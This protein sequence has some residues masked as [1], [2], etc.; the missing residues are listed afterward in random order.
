MKCI[1]YSVTLFS[2]F[3][4]TACHKSRE[5]AP[6]GL[7]LNSYD[8]CVYGG[9]SAGVIAA[10]TA[11]KA[12]KNVL[13]IEPGT[14]LGGLTSGG[15]C[16][17]DVGN[18]T[19]ITGLAKDFYKR[20]GAL[21]GVAVR[22]AFEPKTALS[23]FNQMVNEA[24]ITVMYKTQLN[25]VKKEGTTI[26]ELDVQ[27][28]GSPAITAIVAKEFIDC[29]YEGDLMA[30][31]KVSYTIGRES[32]TAYQETLNGVHLS[33]A[34]QFPNGIDP[35]KIP[36]DPA[37][38]LLWGI[39]SEPLAAEGT[40]DHKIQAYNYRVCLT[41]NTVNLQPITRPAGYDSTQYELLLRYIRKINATDIKTILT[42]NP[43]PNK[44]ADINNQ[45]PFSTDMI[46]E[47]YT[48]PDGDRATRTAIAQ[49]CARYTK[50][51]LYFIGHDPRMPLSIRNQM[52]QW[53]YPLD[54]F[55]ENEHFTSQL[56]IRESRRMLGEYITTQANCEHTSVV[57]D[58]V[59]DA[60]Y[61]MDS[62]NCQRIVVNG[63]VKNEGNV[64]K[65]VRGPYSVSYRSIT[66]KRT[67]CTNL[68]VPVCLSA[69]HIAYGSIRMEPV[70]MMLG[71][72]AA[73]AASLAIDAKTSVQAIDTRVLQEQ[74]KKLNN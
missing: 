22:W 16:W 56:Y 10:Y 70:F 6:A 71:Q 14:R 61:M 46:G 73:Q 47:N 33:V 3:A 62:H 21:Y 74:I 20:V 9:T 31:A 64:E 50:G 42:F 55:E 65:Q 66:P 49:A 60:S 19:T 35:Y 12:G 8:V 63:M 51:L 52:L 1:L 27:N 7:Q 2:L 40:G 5:Q 59:A 17:T 57:N 15:L 18:S 48:Y 36:G 39:S 28:E 34:H 53:G 38:G 54:E 37:S 69:T 11:K 68:L 13:L 26:T 67:E 41:N 25:A 43:L 30:A 45:G 24:N 72:A 29:S 4:A 58:G 32:N 23:V 44:K